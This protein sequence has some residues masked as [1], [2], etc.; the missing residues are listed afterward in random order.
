MPG[1]PV[2][3]NAQVWEYSSR[4]VSVGSSFTHPGHP[5]VL[6]WRTRKFFQHVSTEGTASSI[7]FAVVMQKKTE[8]APAPTSQ[9]MAQPLIEGS[10]STKLRCNAALSQVS[11]GKPARFRSEPKCPEEISKICW[12][13]SKAAVGKTSQFR[14]YEIPHMEDAF[15]PQGGSWSSS[16]EIFSEKVISAALRFRPE[17]TRGTCNLPR[18]NKNG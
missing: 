8:L 10:L 3:S 6:G 11:I 2:G 15:F 14:G 9:Q 12:V 1:L 4:M 16:G 13:C 7:L 17:T 18:R 5:K